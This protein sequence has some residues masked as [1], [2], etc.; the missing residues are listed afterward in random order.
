M[1]NKLPK[2]P[3]VYRVIDRGKTIYIGKTIDIRRRYFQHQ[4]TNPKDI[5]FRYC[6]IKDSKER[7]RIEE[8]L[9]DKLEPRFNSQLSSKNYSKKKQVRNITTAKVEDL[10]LKE[11]LG[12][13]FKRQM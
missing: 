1:S 6:I 7:A 9:I 2:E 11:E 8:S 12:L 5:E 3:G 13:D 4:L 10:Y